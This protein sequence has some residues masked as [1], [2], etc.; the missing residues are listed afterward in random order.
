MTI[1]LS[2]VIVTMTA[3]VFMN[4]S[5]AEQGCSAGVVSAVDVRLVMTIVS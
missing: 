2:A 4:I 1:C 5:L 3:C